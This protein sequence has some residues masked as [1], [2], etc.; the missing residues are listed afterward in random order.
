[1]FY[2]ID[3]A[4]GLTNAYLLLVGVALVA[5]TLFAS[6]GIVGTIRARWIRWLP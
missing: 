5:L 3:Y 4:S 6:Q 1:M 2:L